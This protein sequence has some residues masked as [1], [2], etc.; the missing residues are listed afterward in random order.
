MPIF[1]FVALLTDHTGSENTRRAYYRWVDRYLV[2]MCGFT[3]VPSE[4]RAHRMATLNIRS[5]QRHLSERKLRQWLDQMAENN[6]SRQTLDQARA[7]IVTLADLMGEAGWLDKESIRLIRKVSVPPV[8]KKVTPERI[9]SPKEIDTLVQATQDL[10]NSDNQRIR[11]ALV[12]SLLCTLALRREELSALKWGDI[13]LRDNKPMLKLGKDSLEIPRSI[14]NIIDHWRNCFTGVIQNPPAESPLIR[15]IW[16]GGRIA[17]NGLSA[18]G[19]W[20]TLHEAAEISKLGIV[21]PDD[22]RR[23]VIFNM[24]Q[25]GT[26]VQEIHRLM[27]HRTLLI[28]ERF[29]AKLTKPQPPEA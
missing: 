7:S 21:T 18:D 14:L 9:L 4:K 26:S 13:T 15:R 12:T 27:R 6:H 22:L 17:K 24:V 29:L 16:K 23:S 8:E 10:A 28:T 19:I 1:N 25:T 11:N 2:E 5:L 20:L 3:E